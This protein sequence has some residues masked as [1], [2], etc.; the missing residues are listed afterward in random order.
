MREYITSSCRLSIG[1]AAIQFQNLR[2]GAMRCKLRDMPQAL[3]QD[4]AGNAFEA[5]WL[6]SWSFLGVAAVLR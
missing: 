6:R 4:L 1:I 3:L 2:Y 5:L